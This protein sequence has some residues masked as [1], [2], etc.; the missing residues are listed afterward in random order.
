MLNL[1]LNPE[2]VSEEEVQGF[3]VREAARG[4]VVNERG[5]IALLRVSRDGHYK[6]P[7]GGIDSGEDVETAF[8]RECLEEIGCDVNDITPI[9]IVIEYR[10]FLHLKQVSHC[11]IAKSRGV[12]QPPQFTDHE[13]ERGFEPP[14]WVS[15]DEA[16][17]LLRESR[18]TTVEGRD[19]IVPRDCAIVEKSRTYL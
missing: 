4:I 2:A 17:R 5:E 10:K 3:D 18:A 11:F 15:I 19:Y 8:R 13:I 1:I 7:G 14:I 16:S 6:L 9:G 12:A